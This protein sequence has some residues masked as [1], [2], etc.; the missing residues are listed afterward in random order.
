MNRLV[1]GQPRSKAMSS[2]LSCTSNRMLLDMLVSQL[3]ERLVNKF[4]RLGGLEQLVYDIY[5][6]A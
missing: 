1:P 2:R 3:I 5:R 6:V 4:S